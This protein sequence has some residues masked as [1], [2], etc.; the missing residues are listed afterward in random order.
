MQ[1]DLAGLSSLVP[2]TKQT[3]GPIN[4]MQLEKNLGRYMGSLT[5]PPCSEAVSW[6]I[7]LW[8]VSSSAAL[9]IVSFNLFT[10]DMSGTGSLNEL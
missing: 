9:I 7:N 5:T 8:N 4:L 2:D 10:H 1:L 3:L 6:I